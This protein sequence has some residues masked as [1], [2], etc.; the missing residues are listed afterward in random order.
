MTV[1]YDPLDRPIEI[2]R[3][4]GDLRF[5]STYSTNIRQD[6]GYVRRVGR[7][8]VSYAKMFASQPWIAAAVMRM[9]T[10]SVRVPIKVYRRKDGGDT[11]DR[12]EP[13][14]HP[15]ARMMIRPWLGKGASPAALVQTLLGPMLVHGN[16][17]HEIEI[18]GGEE[19]LRPHDWRDLTPLGVESTGDLDGWRYQYGSEERDIALSKSVHVAWW[20]PL[21]PLGISP[22][23]QLGVTLGVE[24]AAQRYQKSIFGNAARPPSAITSTPE[25]LQ[26]ERPERKGLM[27]QLRQD[28]EEIYSGPENAGKPAVLPPGLDWKPIGSS[29]QEAELIE[30]RKVAREEVAAVYQIP[31]PMIGVLDH[32]TYS[33][34]EVMR[35]MAYTMALGPPLVLIEQI[36]TSSLA[37]DYFGED[38]LY[39]EFDFGP[40]L[41]GDRQKEIATF[42]DAIGTG[43]Q[44][45]NEARRALNLPPSEEPD[46]DRLFYP[47]NNLKPVGDVEA[48]QQAAEQGAQPVPGEGP[49]SPQPEVPI[50]QMEQAE[51]SDAD[52]IEAANWVEKAGGLPKFIKEIANALQREHG[53]TESRAIATAV[54][55]CKKWC[56]GVG[57]VKPDTRAKACAAVAEWQAK[58][59]GRAEVPA[60]ALGEQ[61]GVREVG[62]VEIPVFRIKADDDCGCG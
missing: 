17:V 40:V 31:P 12:V 47:A 21:G 37:R 18:V 60:L 28:V 24:D 62:G 9:L 29:A 46:A 10:W 38:D 19:W 6:T 32:A 15:L 43:I 3:G 20:S 30:Q 4:R 58:K 48:Q 2:A 39:V 49:P 34:I 7:T 8:P 25:F 55:R 57:D 23:E 45:M 59:A 27:E 14:E 61:I 41:R 13:D 51:V 52:I 35:E 11:R 5:S 36:L 42:R 33:N 26:L 1:Y 50:P 22:L 44:T 53:F 54:N 56:A 16:T